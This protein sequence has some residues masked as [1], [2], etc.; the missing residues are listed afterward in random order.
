MTRQTPA[1]KMANRN[2]LAR[3]KANAT[4]AEP[5]KDKAYWMRLARGYVRQPEMVEPVAEYC[6]ANPGTG[7]WH[8]AWDLN[9]RK[10]LCHCTPCTL[11]RGEKLS[12]L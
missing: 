12:C 6:A 4:Q 5:L 11:A 3:S 10:G 9:G 2:A 8:A 1:E 7:M